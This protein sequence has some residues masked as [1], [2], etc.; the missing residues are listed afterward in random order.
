[1]D[2]LTAGAA[3]TTV[4][5]CAS[6]V[7][8]GSYYLAPEEKCTRLWAASGVLMAIGL[9]VVIVNA[10]AVNYTALIVGNNML[11]GGLIVQWRGV[12]ALYKKDASKS[13]WLL[14]ALFF[15]VF[16]LVLLY[17]GKTAE[18]ALLSS[19]AIAFVFTLSAT[20]LWRNRGDQWTFARLLGLSALALLIGGSLFRSVAAFMQLSQYLVTSPS[21]L[22]T[23][24]LYL[25]PLVGTLLFST[26]L[27]LLYLERVIEEKNQLATHDELTK[28]FNRRAIVA[29]GEREI[30]VATRTRQP[31]C[32][33]FLD[34]D[35][36]KQINDQLGHEKGDLVLIELAQVLSQ[37]CRTI[38]WIGRYGGEEFCMVFPGVEAEGAGLIAERLLTQIRRHAF[39]ENRP[40][41]VSIGLAILANED[42][43]RSWSSL[44]NRADSQLY[45]AKSLGRDRYCIA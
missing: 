9:L 6:L 24:V 19:A 15:V 14:F 2:A 39:I 22:G 7:M 26:S 44:I 8:A 17:G 28:L 37:A 23:I 5:L 40:V 29:R 3:L 18:R 1:M 38:D 45:R 21:T 32:V 11:I 10:G 31:L 33:A 12:R 16:G 42:G 4:Q 41:T 35:F 27:L 25:L 30:N 13:G 36:F 43:D 34:V 20:E